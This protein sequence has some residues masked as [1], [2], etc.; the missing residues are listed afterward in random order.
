MA[1]RTILFDA[2][3]TL[4]DFKAAETIALEQT[5]S[6]HAYPCDPHIIARY[7]AI[8]DSLWKAFER[9]EISREVLTETRFMKLFDTLGI[10]GDPAAFNQEYMSNM[11]QQPLLLDGAL[12]LCR[13]LSEEY[14]LYIITNGI[15]KTQQ[16]RFARSQL[17]PY[18]QG[19]F[20]SEETGSQKPHRAYFDYVSAHIPQ[21]EPESTLVVGDSLS[22]D[23]QGAINYGLDCCWFNPE[24]LPYSLSQPCTYEIHRLEELIPILSE[25][26]DSVLEINNKNYLSH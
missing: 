10:H 16:S 4:F 12:E 15:T 6:A 7:S 25:K 21:W 1:Y 24:H 3:M 22:S 8:N 26:Q 23:I 2:D 11:S 5:L 17:T 9:G 19:L 14:R 20:V 13:Y 18:F